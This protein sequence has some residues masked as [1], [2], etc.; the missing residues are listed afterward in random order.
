M[1][2]DINNLLSFFRSLV[3]KSIQIFSTFWDESR[4]SQM[5]NLKNK[6]HKIPFQLLVFYKPACSQK[7]LRGQ[8]LSIRVF[9]SDGYYELIVS[10]RERPLSCHMISLRA[11]AWDIAAD[12]EMK[13]GRLHKVVMWTYVICQPFFS[14][15]LDISSSGVF[16]GWFECNFGHFSIFLLATKNELQTKPYL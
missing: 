6:T 12:F 4:E 3:Q 9:S 14:R 15:V 1:F 11:C 7:I 16:R 13:V 8:V 2:W 5:Y 10:L